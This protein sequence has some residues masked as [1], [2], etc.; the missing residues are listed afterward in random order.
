MEDLSV[1]TVYCMIIDVIN[2]I[3]LRYYIIASLNF[4]EYIMLCLVLR[5]A[6]LPTIQFQ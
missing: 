5:S 4:T 6:S 1:A 3:M 2:G